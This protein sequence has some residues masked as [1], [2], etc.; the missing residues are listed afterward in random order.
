MQIYIVSG[1]AAGLF[2]VLIGIIIYLILEVGKL[3]KKLGDDFND[4]DSFDDDYVNQA[5][6][7]YDPQA[8][9]EQGPTYQ[10]PYNPAETYNI[11]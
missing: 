9:S 7:I 6:A 4:A 3:K 5:N 11:K 8:Q 10:N 2:V 1:I